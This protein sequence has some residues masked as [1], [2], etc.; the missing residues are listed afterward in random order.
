MKWTIRLFMVAAIAA[1]FAAPALAQ[2]TKECTDENK[3]T[4]YTK[5]Y[6]NL[7]KDQS[8]S[9]ATGK[10]YLATC[11]N[12]DDVYTKAIKK[13][14]AAYE[15]A[16]RKSQF[17]DAYTKKNYADE[18]TFGK[19]VLGDDPGN[20]RLYMLLGYIAYWTKDNNQVLATEAMDF[21]KKAIEAIESGKWRKVDQKDEKWDPFTSK[22]ETLSWL[23]YSIGG[24]TL[25]VKKTPDEALPYLLKAARYESAL[26]K[27]HGIYLDIEQAYELGSY[28]KQEEDYK[29]KYFGKDETP[30]SKLALENIYQTLDRMIDAY[31]RAIALAGSDPKLADEKKGWLQNVTELYKYRHNKSDA[32]LNDLIASVLQKPL[33]D[34]PTPITSLPTPATPAGGSGAAGSTTT[35]STGR[36]AG[37]AASPGG[38]KP[39][40]TTQSGSKPAT[41]KPSPTPGTRP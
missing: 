28:A 3:A 8:I 11:P 34:V 1:A 14:M 35:S 30:E 38:N 5:Y 40:P 12:D 20:P 2:A 23:N 17:E 29:Q 32:G 39:S 6:D 24:V 25:T 41:A 13:F 22:D 16:I 15:V 21:A 18:M 4:L 27:F 10:E 9:Y 31:A 37:G 7:K 36:P 19:Q 26:K 33:P